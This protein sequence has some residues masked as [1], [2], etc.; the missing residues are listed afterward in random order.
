MKFPEEIKKM[1]GEFPED[2]EG[3]WDVL[4]SRMA[5]LGI[6]QSETTFRHI[7]IGIVD[8]GL[9]KPMLDVRYAMYAAAA[10]VMA[11]DY[12]EATTLF[13]QQ[14]VVNGLEGMK[15]LAHGS[16]DGRAES[17]ERAR[18]WQRS[19]ERLCG[20]A[21]EMKETIEDPDFFAGAICLPDMS[22][23]ERLGKPAWPPKHRWDDGACTHC[24]LDLEEY[25][26]TAGP[27][28]CPGES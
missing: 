16:L 12:D 18:E 7:F 1:L 8:T 5:D 19:V 20:T 28:I 26:E 25:K 3:A 2:M 23:W 15:L 9:G 14:R 27:Q 24:K 21:Q 6:D 22:T 10:L 4:L 11:D 13:L 17:I